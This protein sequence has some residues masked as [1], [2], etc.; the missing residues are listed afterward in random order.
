MEEPM[1]HTDR[2][3]RQRS[4]MERVLEILEYA[5]DRLDRR[6][7]VPMSVLGDLLEFIDASEE[8]AF[9]ASQ[10]SAGE[11]A[12]SSCVDQHIRTHVPIEGMRQAFRALD[13]GEAAAAAR[14]VRYARDYVRL[15]REHQLADDR[16]FARS[17]AGRREEPD[18]CDDTTRDDTVDRSYRRLLAAAAA[19][20][21][22]LPTRAARHGRF[23]AR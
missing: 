10:V 4:R 1:S 5:A 11:P 12:L 22:G 23:P 19:L 8:A 21:I 17:A 3:D 16:L 14:F 2:F 13:D 15:R 18:G 6:T 9:E 7:Y 20:D